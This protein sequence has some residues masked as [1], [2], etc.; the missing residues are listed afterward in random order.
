MLVCR[1]PGKKFLQYR[2]D[3][4]GGWKLGLDELVPVPYRL[5]ELLEHL[6]SNTADPL[7]I[8][9][10]EK[11]ADAINEQGY[12]AT[13]NPMGAGKWRE[14]YSEWFAGARN[15]II[16]ADNDEPGRA[17]AGLVAREL[18]TVGVVPTQLR[19]KQGKDVSDHLA[20]GLP[21][22]ELVPLEGA[23]EFER[24]FMD[25]YD[26]VDQQVEPPQPLW[27]SREHIIIPAGGLVV[28]AGRPG[29]GKTTWVVD[30]ACHLAAGLAYPPPGDEHAPEPWPVPRPLRV[31]LIE[32]EG[33]IEMFRDK[34]GQ[35]LERWPHPPGDVG[36]WLG[37]QVWR[38]GA[39]S[40]ADTDTYDKVRAELDEL[41]IDLVIGDPLSMLGTEGVGSPAE[42]R[43][44]VQLIRGLGLGHGRAFLFLHHFRERVERN[45][46]ELARISG[47]WGPHLDTLMTLQPMG[48][49]EEARLAFPKLR[50]GRGRS[51][52]PIVLGK[53]YNTQSFAGLRK[54]GDM[55]ALEPLIVGE[56]Q[57]RR[58]GNEGYG[59]NGWAT[60]A[61]LA[62]T[63]AGGRAKDRVK[64]TLEAAPHLFAMVTGDEARQLGAKAKTAK[65]WGLREWPEAP[66]HD[67]ESA[68]GGQLVALPLD[69][70]EHQQAALGEDEFPF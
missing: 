63:I 22:E 70:D 30:L 3:G 61:Q 45:E 34:L 1:Y 17:H 51:P 41:D 49:E 65:L 40:F 15:V 14:E 48:R 36:G 57:R 59:G 12:T 52:E 68:P 8:V 46:D 20:A 64:K 29:V 9:E 10:G 42:T 66:E 39:F 28:A 24:I 5:P 13:C 16:V 43:D 55:A 25:A 6:A 60:Y 18:G 32:N 33:P 31:V 19:S 26:F 37:V 47:A 7:Y 69:G 50:W 11:D 35:K 4:Q 27:G 44:F 38:W 67:E 21:L 2:P 56:L 58:D 23:A 62:P 53:I 54:E